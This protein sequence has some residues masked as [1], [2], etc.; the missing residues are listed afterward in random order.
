[1][2]QQGGR[3]RGQWLQATEGHQGGS[4]GVPKPCNK[5]HSQLPPPASLSASQAVQELLSMGVP[6]EAG[7]SC[8][9]PQSWTKTWE[10]KPAGLEASPA[11]GI[12]LA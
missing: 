4:W 5:L 2:W 10:Q 8:P 12:C 9:L 6:G 7:G 11:E 1:M 3:Q